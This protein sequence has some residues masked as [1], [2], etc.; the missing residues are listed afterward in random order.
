M[1]K[2]VRIAPSILSADFAKLLIREGQ[3]LIK[4][5]TNPHRFAS[6]V[7]LKAPDTPS[8]L[9]ESGYLTN[10]QDVALLSSRSG[11]SKVAVGIANAIEAHFARQLAQR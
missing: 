11:R 8:V 10:E 4:F 5:R 2:P 9:F 6:L 3:R 1:Q 7:V